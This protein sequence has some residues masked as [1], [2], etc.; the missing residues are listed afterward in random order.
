MAGKMKNVAV[1]KKNGKCGKMKKNGKVKSVANE[2]CDTRKI[3]HSINLFSV[4]T[5]DI[6]DKD[7]HP[8]DQLN[9]LSENS[10]LR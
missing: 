7:C 9:F 10:D 2:K 3:C 6:V 5:L 8:P 1:I 4:V